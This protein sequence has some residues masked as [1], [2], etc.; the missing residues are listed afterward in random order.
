MALAFFKKIDSHVGVYA[1]EKAA[2][3]YGI[4][5]SILILILFRQMDHPGKMLCER[6]VIAGISFLLVWLYHSFPCKC[7]AFIRVCFQ[8]SMLSY[9]YP[10]TYEFN[11]LFP[12]LDHIFAWVEHQV[13]GNQPSILFSQYF[14]QIHVSEAFNLG[15]FSYYP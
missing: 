4:L 8:M 14:P 7:F 11:R 1:I 5:T 12:N 13:F 9:W 2:L 6:M 15:Y 3:V 10:D